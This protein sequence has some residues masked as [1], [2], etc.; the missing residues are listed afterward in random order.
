MKLNINRYF[1]NK[2]HFYEYTPLSENICSGIKGYAR[3]SGSFKKPIFLIY[4]GKEELYRLEENL[5]ESWFAF[6]CEL[7]PPLRPK[8]KLWSNNFLCSTLKY[9]GKFYFIQLDKCT[10]YIRGASKC[11]VT[12]W[13]D[14]NQIGL[15][16][17]TRN[18]ITAS[19]ETIEIL[20]EEGISK[21]LVLLFAIFGWEKFV[22]DRTYTTISFD[23][24][25]IDVNWK[26]KDSI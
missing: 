26:P 4:K 21:E 1:N 11:I 5:I 13:K 10:Y 7:V 14:D 18:N 20:Y 6:L 23:K 9:S 24:Y 3:N 22:G 17:R 2:T 16:R 25:P 15:I 8:H 12:I 19:L